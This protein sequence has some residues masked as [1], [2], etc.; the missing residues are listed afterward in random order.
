MMIV[1][2][3]ND[4]ANIQLLFKEKCF[5]LFL[6]EGVSERDCS[7]TGREFQASGPA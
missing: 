2:S 5:Q 7:V 3:D 6:E 1:I 4:G